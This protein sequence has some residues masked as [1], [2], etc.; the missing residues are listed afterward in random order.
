MARAT[1]PLRVPVPEADAT[2][3]VTWLADEVQGALDARARVIGAGGDLDYWQWLYEQGR[4]ATKDK[5][6]ADA[7]DLGSY[8]PT[9]KVDA[10][11]ARLVRTIFTEPIWVVEGWGADAARAPLVEEWHQWKAEEER[12]QGILGKVL[13]QSLVEGTGVLEVYEKAE[14]R[15]Q[16]RRERVMPRLNPDGGFELDARGLPQPDRD[17][18]GAFVPVLRDEAPSVE[19]LVRDP[20]VVRRGPGYRVL[21]LR[22]FL[23]LPGHAQDTQ[24]VWGYAKRFWRRMPD[25]RQREAEGVYRDVDRLDD[26]DEREQT[27]AMRL[28]GQE[29]A[30]QRGPTAEKEL[31]EVQFLA[32]LDED[33][34]EEWYVATL[35]VS[36]R[37]LLRLQHEDLGRPRYLLFTPLPRPDSVYGYSLVGHKLATVA[38]EHTALRNMIADRSALV[39]NAPIKRMAGALWDP[40]EQPWGAR[41]VIDV[42]DPRELEPVTVPDVPTSAIERERNIVT[43][44]E[45]VSGLND[46]ALGTLPQQDRTLGEVQL[47]TEQSFVRMEESIHY[48]QE[49]L[50][51]LWV[52][53]QELWLRA[54]ETG[55]ARGEA[56]PAGMVRSLE[57]R[58]VELEQAGTITAANLRGKFRGKPRGSVETAD[59]MRLRQDF[60]GL[61]QAFAA[62]GKM[63]PMVGQYLGQPQAVR[64]LLEQA[65]R[66]YRVPDR[67]AFL[68]APGMPLMA[69]PLLP[70]MGVGLPPGAG[71]GNPMLGGSA[72]VSPG[73][74]GPPGAPPG[75]GG[76][77]LWSALASGGLG[78][79]G[80]AAGA[81]RPF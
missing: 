34:L 76:P 46:V 35:S 14:R 68:G 80:G 61:L 70:G 41:A 65:L 10:L 9:E 38:E 16:T 40:A 24:G 63:F 33:G 50:E 58:G 18:A 69:P 71:P 73:P 32:D 7:A 19:V 5:P 74:G 62:L 53:R 21:S 37:V 43:V 2:A 36:R 42:R 48:L 59:L 60:N 64:A 26:A 39:T 45:R 75:V 77:G 79:P 15:V 12:L 28:A 57:M 81:P 31:W 66:V 1:D 13:H 30:T 67:Q 20:S 11:R 17:E 78:G 6:W 4:R 55:E 3:L 22:D 52:L 27:Q 72:G 56:V 54:L 23:V 51:D 29:I 8:I 44:A 47:V 49:T 25:L